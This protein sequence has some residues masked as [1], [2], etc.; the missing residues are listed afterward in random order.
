MECGSKPAVRCIHVI[1]SLKTGFAGRSGRRLAEELESLAAGGPVKVTYHP[2]D[3][4]DSFRAVMLAIVAEAQAGHYP[5]I[6]IEAH[7]APREAGHSGTSR[8][9]ELASG[10]VMLWTEVA[11]F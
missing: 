2:V 5:L 10:E 6:H 8:G 9:I 4:K 3:G 1:E 7:G 11:P